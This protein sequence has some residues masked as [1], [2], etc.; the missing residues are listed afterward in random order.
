MKT[1]TSGA[2]RGLC[3]IT[4]VGGAS[5][6]D[7][8]RDAPPIGA[9]SPSHD[10]LGAWPAFLNTARIRVLQGTVLLLLLASVACAQDD[11]PIKVYPCPKAAT[12]PVMD[13]KLDDAVWQTAP[14][15]SAF[16]MYGKDTLAEVQTSFRVLWDDK[17]LYFGVTCDE[18]MMD[19]LAPVVFARDEHAVFSNE[20]IELFLDP[21]HTHDLYYQLAMNAGASLYDGRREDVSW[22]SDTIVKAHLDKTFWSLEVAVP[23]ASLETRPQAGKVVGFNVCRDRNLGDKE[24]TNWARTVS[25]FHDPIRFAHLV[26]SGTPDQ[27]GKLSAEMRKGDR[28]GPIT[29]FSSEGFSQSTYV[30]LA[31]TAFADLQKL[32]ADLDAERAREKDA[33]TA[34]ELGKR[35][36]AYRQRVDE[37]RARSAAKLDAAEW[38]RMDVDIQ[39]LIREMKR[40]VWE[41]RLSALLTGI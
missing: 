10:G 15:V 36:D 13:G 31:N 38:V 34:A 4:T 28:S 16:T 29:I 18:P 24:W 20:T 25:G 11:F 9:V 37:F 1:A 19:K 40:V 32:L 6:P 30:Q 3:P 5:S 41:A 7:G 23:W 22:N 27:I 39:K 35:L 12:A 14:V 8:S 17:Y 21:D 2:V 26:L 33:A